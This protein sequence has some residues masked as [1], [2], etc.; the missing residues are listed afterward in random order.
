MS[1]GTFR[2][3]RGVMA[4]T[5]VAVTFMGM[6]AA[7]PANAVPVP[8]DPDPGIPTGPDD[9][10]C[11]AMSY[12]AQC[13]GGP[14]AVHSPTGPA[15]LACV[16]M[17]ADP[18]CAGGPD[19]PPTAAGVTQARHPTPPPRR[20]SG[21][22]TDTCARTPAG[23]YSRTGSHARPGVRPRTGSYARAGPDAGPGGGCRDAGA[24]LT[25]API[26]LR[27][28]A[29]CVSAGGRSGRPASTGRARG[30]PGTTAPSTRRAPQ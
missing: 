7:V 22:H 26:R 14:F 3:V 4:K 16:T 18:V 27:W 6:I 19:A 25:T 15:D 2:R 30:G 5:A 1:R 28:N 24:H 10:R 17:P 11:A 8:L 20:A 9:P 13:Q 21:R 23:C 12:L 29:F